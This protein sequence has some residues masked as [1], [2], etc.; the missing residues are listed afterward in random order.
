MTRWEP[1]D[2][3]DEPHRRPCIE[4]LLPELATFRRKIENIMLAV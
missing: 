4:V 1:W 2:W 3:P